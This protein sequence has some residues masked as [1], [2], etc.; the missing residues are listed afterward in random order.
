MA[1]IDLASDELTLAVELLETAYR[2]LK[3]EVYKTEGL[4]S[5]T[6]LKERERRIRAIID[7]LS[8]AAGITG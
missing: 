2:D 8:G 7:K 4:S 1:S 5:K 6:E 3:E